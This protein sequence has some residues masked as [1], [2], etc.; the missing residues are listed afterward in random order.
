MSALWA[1]KGRAGVDSE[2]SLDSLALYLQSIGK[3]DTAHRRKE[4][5]RQ[6]H[7]A[8]RLRGQEEMVEANL[9]LVVS[10]AKPT[11]RAGSASST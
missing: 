4:S 2:Q 11:S 3:V 5:A 7:R 1:G 6:A 9:R 10:I 8:R